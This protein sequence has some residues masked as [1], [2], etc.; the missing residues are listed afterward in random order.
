MS[1]DIISVSMGLLHT[2]SFMAITKC[3]TEVNPFLGSYIIESEHQSFF[4][5]VSLYSLC[6][7]LNVLNVSLGSFLFV[8]AL[9]IWTIYIDIYIWTIYIY[10]HLDIY[11]PYEREG[12]GLRAGHEGRKCPEINFHCEIRRATT[13]TGAHNYF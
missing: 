3:L 8:P 4:F 10:I 6:F 2:V 9:Y 7:L 13:G 1:G 11:Q 5:N 12:K